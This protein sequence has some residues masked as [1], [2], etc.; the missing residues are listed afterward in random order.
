[1]DIGIGFEFAET[2]VLKL[3]TPAGEPLRNVKGEQMWIEQEGVDSPKWR[4]T[5]QAAFNRRVK[6]A[7]GAGG[8]VTITAAEALADRIANV[9]AVA[10]KWGGFITADGQP[11]ECTTDNVRTCYEEHAFIFDQAEAHATNRENFMRADSAA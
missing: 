1:M 8:R 7:Q 10:R 3:Q 6:K 11:I 5:E 9:A 4:R 2:A